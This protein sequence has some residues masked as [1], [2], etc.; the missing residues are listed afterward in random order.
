MQRRLN[1]DRN[2]EIVKENTNKNRNTDKNNY[3]NYQKQPKKA[4]T[5]KNLKINPNKQTSQ[6]NR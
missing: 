3:Y 2:K 5:Y 1:K 4:H 6:N